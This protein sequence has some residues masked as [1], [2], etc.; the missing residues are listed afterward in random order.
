LVQWLILPIAEMSPGSKL[1]IGFAACRLPN[2]KTI[3]SQ[4]HRPSH[5]RQLLQSLIERS[6]QLRRQFGQAK[7]LF[8]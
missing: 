4:P 7:N 6:S 2:A 5:Y 1:L 8:D 3:I